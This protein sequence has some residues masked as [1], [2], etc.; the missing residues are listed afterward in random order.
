MATK[1]NAN[2]QGFSVRDAVAQDVGLILEFIRAL[3]VYEKMEDQ[4][5]ATEEG[6]RIALF[7]K[8]GAEVIIG[9]EK[10]KAVAFALYFQ[11]FSTFV[12]RANLYLEDLYV[13]PEYGGKGYGRAMFQHL[14]S[15]AVQRG[16][17]RLDWW[18]LDWNE[19]A[20]S[21]YKKLGAVPMEEWTVYRLQGK[22]LKKAAQ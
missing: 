17:Q 21:F 7:E 2:L 8:H 5:E 10:G 11:N 14:A 16:C 19:S 18:C 1:Q 9:E 4:V 15:V 3:A 20:A 22:A 12:G 13:K 6:L